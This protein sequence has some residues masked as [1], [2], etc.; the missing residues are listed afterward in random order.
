MGKD[1]IAELESMLAHQQH[2]FDALNEVVIE[3]SKL[4]EQF[5]LRLHHIETSLQ[6]VR[7]QMP[8]EPRDPEAEK[9]PHY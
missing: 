3:Q 7:E 6:N 2:A 8:A 4:L 5:H 9:P 1:R